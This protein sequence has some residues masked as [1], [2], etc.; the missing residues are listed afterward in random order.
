LELAVL[1]ALLAQLPVGVVVAS[2][3]GRIVVTY[4]NDAA[5]RILPSDSASVDRTTPDGARYQKVEWA[6]A[7]A[8]LLG[9]VVR[10]EE[11]DFVLPDG[12]HRWLSVSATPIRTDPDRIDGAVVTF[13][14][15]TAVKQAAAWQPVIE[16]L[17]R[18]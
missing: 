17:Y 8:L 4:E 2:G 10:D 12:T 7:R 14:D 13:A 6:M 16:S 15:V 9:E 11:I 1:H 18:L 5:R 3:K